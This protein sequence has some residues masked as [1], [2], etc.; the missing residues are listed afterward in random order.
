MRDANIRQSGFTLIASLLLLVLMSGLAI[1][2]MMMVNTEQRAGGNDVE[3]SLAYRGAEAGIESM[4]A[5]IATQF[6]NQAAPTAASI[7]AL[8]SAANEPTLP[9]ITFTGFTVTPET[10][11]DGTLYE[12]TVTISGGTDA[13]LYA[14]TVTAD[15]DVTAQRPNGEQVHMLRTIQVALIPVF[16][17]GV[18]SDSDVDFFAGPNFD[19]G[20]RIHTNGNLFLADIGTLTL[21]DKI[22]AFKEV[23]RQQLANGYLS[24]TDYPGQVLVP[25]DSTGCTAGQTTANSD[26]RNL[27]LTEASQ[28]LQGG[29]F[30]ANNNWGGTG[31]ISQGTYH[32][33]ITTGAT[34]AKKLSLP[35]VGGN[36]APIEIIHRP[37]LPLGSADPTAGP[38]R[39][40]NIAQIRVLISDTAAQNHADGTAADAQDVELDNVGSY[41]PGTGV[42]VTGVGTQ[43]YFAHATTDCSNEPT[44]VCDADF[45]PN[46]LTPGATEWPLIDGYLR[47]E[48][49][50]NDGAWHPITT[51][52]LSLGFAR[53]IIPPNSAAGQANNVHP[54]AILIFQEQADRDGNGTI[55]N[56]KVSGSVYESTAIRGSNTQYNWFP[57]NLYD[58]R[59]GDVRDTDDGTCYA[60]GVMNLVEVDV[61]NLRKWLNGTIAG[62]GTSVNSTAQNGYILYFSDRRGMQAN[63]NGL[64]A[65]ANANNVLTGEFGFE[66]DV[67]PLSTAGTP[68]GGNPDTGEDA[69]QNGIL[70]IWGAANVGDGFG[71]STVANPY[72]A[73][74]SCT[75][76][77]KNKV[78]GARHG[79]RLVNGSGSNLPTNPAAN[80][81][82]GGTSG[83]FTVASENPVYVLGDY[84]AAAAWTDP[85]AAA[86]VVADAVTFLSNNWTDME[87]FTSPSTATNRNASETW[88]R[89][90]IAAGKNINFPQPTGGWASRDYGTDGGM[91]NFLR[92]LEDWGG[93]N[94]HYEGS[95]V[96]LFY[97]EYATG[98]FKCCT[99]V[100]G[101]PNRLYNYDLLFQDHKNL[102]PGTPTLKDVNNLT[103]RQDF[104]PH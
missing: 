14:Q 41:A 38:S 2:L 73:V 29:S 39:L 103:S 99:T 59:E 92:Y 94:A 7:A 4:D 63:P 26:C 67:N 68:N 25:T 53:G 12:P 33:Y 46:R 6:V 88:Y 1:S 87:S 71:L 50:W 104:T 72:K 47:V 54:N 64:T 3:N 32:S 13:G 95:L 83:G 17:F 60:N 101:A 79:L 51:E 91:H 18:F 57:I 44:K 90:A 15:L 96:S 77:R 27:A 76:G 42:N 84:N 66:D 97:S 5:S 69:D 22:S 85:H 52:W 8:G 74:A 9:G 62:T 34:G 11:P 55:K 49:K 78:S 89:L 36:A 35:F 20:G 58:T 102:P 61:N 19:F 48:A 10:N 21:H 93:V 37:P 86:S 70:D 100:Y 80:P 31:G 30:Q 40:Y 24:S 45:I 16:Q 75:K 82:P 81:D 23:Y 43:S 65:G 56:G 28:T 98:I